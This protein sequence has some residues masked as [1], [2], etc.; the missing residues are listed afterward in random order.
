M[1]NYQRSWYSAQRNRKYIKL[2]DI[3]RRIGL[4]DNPFNYLKSNAE[5][6]EINSLNKV[7]ISSS[8]KNISRSERN[9][10]IEINFESE[11]QINSRTEPEDH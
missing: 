3:I 7:E 8:T 4:K 9:A 6:A 1:I 11:A 10:E 5:L 2:S